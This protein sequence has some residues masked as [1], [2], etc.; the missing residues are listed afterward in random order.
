MTN[1]LRKI[2]L[3]QAMCALALCLFGLAAC[4]EKI[5]HGENDHSFGNW[6]VV[7]PAECE[8]DGVE[9][10]RC[11]CGATTTR[12]IPAPGHDWKRESTTK[13]PTCTEE[14]SAIE[15]CSRCGDDRTVPIPP[16][17]HK[18]AAGDRGILLRDATCTEPG[19][20][21]K[22]CTVCKQPFE[23]PIPAYGHSM[24]ALAGEE[25][26]IKLPT[27]EEKGQRNGVCSVC[28]T[29]EV[30]D[31][32]AL[33]HD[34]E[35]TYTIDSP[36]T[37]ESSGSMSIHCT[38]CESTKQPIG[39]PK[40]DR[41]QKT[42]YEFRIVRSDGTTRIP[43]SGVAIAVF[44]ESG[45]KVAEGTTNSGKLLL[46]GDSGLLPARYT[47]QVSSCPS[48]YTAK[49]SYTFEAGESLCRIPL[50]AQLLTTAPSDRTTYSEGSVMHDFSVTTVRG[51]TVSLSGL[52]Q[53]KKIVVLNFWATWCGPCEQEFPALAAVLARYGSDAAVIALSS[54]T[55]ADAEA[56]VKAY[57][58]SHPELSAFYVAYSAEVN[59]SARFATG[60]Y[61][62]TV[63][64]DREGVVCTVHAGAATEEEFGRLFARYLSETPALAPRSALAPRRKE[65]E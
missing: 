9:Q 10:G 12:P 4:G 28:G 35:K 7:T 32:P 54:E 56:K 1:K 38:R 37:F 52:L 23:D 55:T 6:E 46:T 62:T 24:R 33:G 48:G 60:V 30:M 34:W 51:E 26:V 41:N 8:K 5:E 27:C 49:E 65:G 50:Y 3:I 36:A 43:K 39:I 19:A 47:V 61:P 22:T 29:Q 42:D 11:A 21:Q 58:N 13:S 63:I 17:G 2:L 14:G 18:A 64:V 20:Y 31:I 40:L 44:D 59:L 53:T 25:N 57:Y 45:A 15:K 16:T